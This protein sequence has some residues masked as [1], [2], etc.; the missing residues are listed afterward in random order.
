MKCSAC[1]NNRCRRQYDN[2]YICLG[3][4]ERI[5]CTCTCQ[6][7]DLETVVT[8]AASVV[9][10]VAL[11]AGGVA[12]AASPIGIFAAPL[13]GACMG[14]GGSMIVNPITKKYNGEHMTLESS[15]KDFAFGAV[16]GESNSSS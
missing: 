7:S 2:R 1:K 11:M 10:G 13:G 15:A 14:A 9:G 5:E 16:A 12:V 3:E 8:S 6:V 4:R